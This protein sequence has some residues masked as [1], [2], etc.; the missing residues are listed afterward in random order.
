MELTSD[1]GAYDEDVVGARE[2]KVVGGRMEVLVAVEN[3]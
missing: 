2:R 3:V 1:A